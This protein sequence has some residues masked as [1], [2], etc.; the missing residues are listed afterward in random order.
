MLFVFYLVVSK[1][2]EQ[3]LT[4]STPNKDLVS[5]LDHNN[6]LTTP[7]IEN[8]LTELNANSSNGNNLTMQTPGSALEIFLP[9]NHPLSASSSTR[10]NFFD[11][12]NFTTPNDEKSFFNIICSNPYGT[13][14]NSN[15]TNKIGSGG[16]GSSTFKRQI[17]EANSYHNDASNSSSLININPNVIFTMNNTDGNSANKYTT[18]TSVPNYGSP[19]T[20]ESRYV[21]YKNIKGLIR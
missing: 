18:L 10:L 19:S 13:T 20:Y 2:K 9:N 8:L 1:K 12:V 11:T 17:S 21:P 3:K 16:S 14:N 6:N 7:Q 15:V 5:H 4:T